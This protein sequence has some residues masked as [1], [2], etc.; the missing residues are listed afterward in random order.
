MKEEPLPST[1]EGL[2]ELGLR[3]HAELREAMGLE[4]ASPDLR[5]VPPPEEP[6][7]PLYGVEHLRA[8][9]AQLQT[10]ARPPLRVVPEDDSA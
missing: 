8:V 1:L 9:V 7:A 3:L 10:R 4:P 5:V 2:R 6:P